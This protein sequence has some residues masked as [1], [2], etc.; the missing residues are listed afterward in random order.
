MTEELREAYKL[1]DIIRGESEV[2]CACEER[3]VKCS[4]KERDADDNDKP[5]SSTQ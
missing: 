3:C 5:T 1:I 4:C 2:S